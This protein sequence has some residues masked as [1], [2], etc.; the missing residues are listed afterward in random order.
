VAPRNSLEVKTFG[1]NEGDYYSEPSS[2]SI[3]PW[4]WVMLTKWK[5]S[6]MDWSEQLCKCEG[7]ALTRAVARRKPRDRMTAGRKAQGMDFFT[8]KTSFSV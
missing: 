3:C 6:R 8:F 2:R 7:I 4:T 1:V 5:W